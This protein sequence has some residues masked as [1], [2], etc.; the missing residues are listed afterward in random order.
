ML[1]L[2]SDP[3]AGEI[4]QQVEAVSRDVVVEESKEDSKEDAEGVAKMETTPPATP[5]HGCLEVEEEA[6]GQVEY[7]A[8]YCVDRYAITYKAQVL[9]PLLSCAVKPIHLPFILKRPP[10]LI[11]PLSHIPVVISQNNP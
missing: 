5:T 2:Q 9:Y 7:Y 11:R 10:C 8:D 6:P 4:K 1:S 3:L